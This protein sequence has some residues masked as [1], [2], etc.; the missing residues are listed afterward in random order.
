MARMAPD[1]LAV[2]ASSAASERA[3]S[4]GGNIITK[5]PNRLAPGTVGYLMCLRSW[6]V[7]PE[8]DYEDDGLADDEISDNRD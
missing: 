7:I 6:G 3:F 2:P 8:V 1:H 5:N 4:A